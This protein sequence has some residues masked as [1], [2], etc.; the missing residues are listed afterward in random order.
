[1]ISKAAEI[2]DVPE[3]TLSTFDCIDE[4]NDNRLEGVLCRQMDKNYGALVIF[5]VNG[6]E[7]EVQKI[8]C[9][10]K[11]RYP[12]STNDLGERT[13]HWPKVSSV[14][15]YEKYDGTN[16]FCY[17]YYDAN[18]QYYRT[19]KTRLTPVVSDLGFAKFK[20]L[21]DEALKKY[22]EFAALP[23][24]SNIGYSFELYGY[25]NP[26]LIIYDVDID[27]KLLFLVHR[28]TG[29]LFLPEACYSSENLHAKQ[30]DV[31]S[32]KEMLTDKYNK[33]RN[34]GQEENKATDDGMV[35]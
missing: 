33:L 29:E 6:V 18:N 25:K 17:S 3:S 4:Y 12:F 28:H 31:Y 5:K 32:N 1:M 9:T 21:L 16:I 24:A 35:Q 34:L 15:V 14:F 30:T 20:T 2:L 27:L 23:A 10:P 13:Y 19:Y 26:H 7:V 8:L 11:I 22:P